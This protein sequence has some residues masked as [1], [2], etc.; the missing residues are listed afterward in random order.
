T[1]LRNETLA[2]PGVTTKRKPMMQ[3]NL[4]KTTDPAK[5][6]RLRPIAS[7]FATTPIV[8]T[9]RLVRTYCYSGLRAWSCVFHV[10]K[11]AAHLRC[12]DVEKASPGLA[13][14]HLRQISRAHQIAVA[15]AGRAAAFIERPDNQALATPAIAGSEDAFDVSGVFVEVGFGV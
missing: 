3:L 7:R 8:K 9:I 14:R 15:F 1:S 2:H 10:R 13:A 5:V 11:K 12:D 4:V 6:L